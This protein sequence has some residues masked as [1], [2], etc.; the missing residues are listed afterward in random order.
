MFLVL[1]FYLFFSKFSHVVVVFDPGDCDVCS[2]VVQTLF[3]G[4]MIP[5]CCC[6]PKEE[7]NKKLHVLWWSSDTSL[8][9]QIIISIVFVVA[10]FCDSSSSSSST[11]KNKLCML[12]MIGNVMCVHN[13]AQY[14][15]NYVC[16]VLCVCHM[17][18]LWCTTHTRISS[19][20]NL[21]SVAVVIM[22]IRVVRNGC[23]CCCCCLK[24]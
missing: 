19:S 10:G 12:S 20:S 4:D 8:E 2:C 3:T 13:H 7:P 18:T 9:S 17:Y 24:R 6:G 23:E 15:Y 22:Y 16:G 14:Y 5:S 21:I 11:E 1:L